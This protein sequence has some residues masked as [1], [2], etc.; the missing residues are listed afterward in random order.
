MHCI[1]A[2]SK[3]LEPKTTLAANAQTE[4]HQMQLSLLDLSLIIHAHNWDTAWLEAD[5]SQSSIAWDIGSLEQ[6]WANVQS[7]TSQ[8][9][10]KSSSGKLPAKTLQT[11][12]PNK[13]AQN[14]AVKQ[15]WHQTRSSKNTPAKQLQQKRSSK[16]APAKTLKCPAIPLCRST[17]TSTS[18]HWMCFKSSGAPL[19][20]N[21]KECPLR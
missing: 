6:T 10:I 4:Q 13:N 2:E 3:T 21:W 17:S 19:P 15:T 11:K 1:Y 7:G 14:T 16:N 9:Y 8:I 18:T 5:L 20:K 12:R